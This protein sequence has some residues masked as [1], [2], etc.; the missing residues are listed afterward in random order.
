[1]ARSGINK[2]LVARARAALLARGQ[3]PTIDAVRIELGN[4]GSKSTIHRYLREIDDESPQDQPEGISLSDE[5]GTLVQQLAERLQQ[6]AAA[7]LLRDRERF[8]S[9]RQQWLQDRQQYEQRIEQYSS[10]NATATKALESER[11]AHGE[12]Q[13][14]CSQQQQRISQLLHSLDSEK[15]LSEER[16]QQ[17][18]S[19]E[20]KHRNARDALE[21]FRTASQQQRE[22][23]QRRFEAERQQL[24]AELRQARHTHSALQEQLVQLSRDNERLLGEWRS[25]EKLKG[26]A[27][28]AKDKAQ[29]AL[30]EAG[31]RAQQLAGELEGVQRQ[32]LDS[33]QLRETDQ[34]QLQAVQQQMQEMDGRLGELQQQ[35]NTSQAQR[36]L[37]ERLLQTQ[38][39]QPAAPQ[40]DNPL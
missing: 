28:D 23:E 12:M 14:V 7:E 20:D 15:A 33:Q 24:Q 29:Q 6:E 22:Q 13:A 32:L 2:A 9:E 36:E 4:T 3:Q 17:I 35:L 10:E 39:T 34:Q 30:S 1:M 21:H 31:Q 18:A 16:S 25:C 26:Q 37:L 27:E 19:L 38:Q 5:L 40:P 11:L 8:A